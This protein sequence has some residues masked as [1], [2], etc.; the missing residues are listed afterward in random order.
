MVGTGACVAFGADGEEAAKQPFPGR[1]L[2]IR[3]QAPQGKSQALSRVDEW[4]FFDDIGREAYRRWQK[5]EEVKE[6]AVRKEHN[7]LVI[8]NHD[9]EM[10]LMIAAL[11]EGWREER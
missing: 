8:E 4:V 1:L 5:R 2:A 7:R 10:E 6:D 3:F 9:P 11:E